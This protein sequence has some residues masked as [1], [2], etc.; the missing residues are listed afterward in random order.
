MGTCPKRQT[1]VASANVEGIPLHE[2]D[3]STTTGV[4]YSCVVCG[5]V[6]S[7][8]VDPIAQKNQIVRDTVADLLKA[9]SRR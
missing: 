3:G 7:V 2:L 5:Q 4:K 8:G 9:L 6:L 1:I